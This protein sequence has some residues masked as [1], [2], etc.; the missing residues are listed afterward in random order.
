[1]LGRGTTSTAAGDARFTWA[2][3]RIA[4]CWTIADGTLAVDACAH[5]AAGM[6]EAQGVDV[7]RAQDLRRSWLAAGAHGALRWR[8]TASVFAELQA[9]ASVPFLRDRFYFTPNVLIHQAAA[10]TPWLALGV[11]V[12]FW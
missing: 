3:A 5:V 6:L 10:V 11:G 2:V 12:R 8:A 7:V 9:G 1:V 4:G